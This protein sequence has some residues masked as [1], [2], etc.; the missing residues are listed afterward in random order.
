MK[1]I[2]IQKPY[3]IVKNQICSFDI[4]C[5]TYYE[6]KSKESKKCDSVDMFVGRNT[7]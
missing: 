6:K 1:I 4:Y 5:D 3:Y 7:F 2:T